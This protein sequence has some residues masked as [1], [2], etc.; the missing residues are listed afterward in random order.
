ME[1]QNLAN[2]LS[3]SMSYKNGL[4]GTGLVIDLGLGEALLE[5]KRWVSL[6]P[7]PHTRVTCSNLP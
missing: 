4:V 6:S 1:N 5:A 3:S 2:N 7:H